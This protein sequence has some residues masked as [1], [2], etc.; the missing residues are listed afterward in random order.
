MRPLQKKKAKDKDG[1][2]YQYY[3]QFT[4]FI[5]AGTDFSFTLD[6]EP[7]IPG[8]GEQ[9]SAYRLLSRICRNYHKAFTIVIGDALYLNEKI[10]KLLETHHKKIIA[11][12]KEERRQLFEEANKLSL[13]AEPKIY[14]EG[15]TSYR[16]WDHGVSGCWDGYGKDV[17]VIVS[18]ETTKKRVHSEDGKGWIDMTE[19]SNWMWSTNVG[20]DDDKSMGD[21]KNTVKVCHARW[22]IEN[23]C[24]RETVNTWNA[25]H[26]YRHSENAIVVFLLF[27]FICVNIFS[28]FFSRNIKDKRIRT[29]VFLIKEINAEFISLKRPLP[30]VPIPI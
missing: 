11:V 20:K 6:I 7:V 25:D 19:V 16:V 30:P 10:F 9:T 5:L 3:H 13:L 14:R 29:R 26:I 18:E 27:L 1:I 21:L 24:F 23:H 4:A 28:I 22:H 15:A 12:L 2:K 17:R 8:E